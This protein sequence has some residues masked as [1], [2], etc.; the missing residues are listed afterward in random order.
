MVRAKF[1]CTRK[2]SSTSSNGYGP[3]PS[4]PVDT[5]EVELMAVMG[6][7]NKEWSKWTP[8]GSLKMQINN[9]DAIAQFEVGKDY[10]LDFTPAFKP[11][12]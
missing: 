3:A 5:E 6:D 7:D 10:F 11:E 12:T 1:R 8:S 4:T 9:P 2:T